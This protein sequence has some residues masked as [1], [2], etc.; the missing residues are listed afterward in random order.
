MALRLLPFRQYDEHDVVNMYSLE[1]STFTDAI[2]NPDLDGGNADGVLVSTVRGDL[3]SD[4]VRFSEKN[5]TNEI[6]F[7]SHPSPVGR[8]MYPF[9]YNYVKAVTDYTD[10]VLGV[11]LNQTLK[12]DENGEPLQYRAE[13]RD[14]LQAVLPYKTVPIAT[15][16][17]FTF[18]ANAFYTGDT[19]SVGTSLMGANNAAPQGV[20]RNYDTTSFRVRGDKIG[21]I[22]ATGSRAA[23]DAYAGNYYLVKLDC[24]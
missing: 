5:P 17:L 19:F 12:Y 4:P 1:I 21:T 14:E 8:N 24:T 10:K 9:T 22:L 2:E 15:R 18:N 13:K 3:N 23:D 6:T 20:F 16:G 11:T 7:K